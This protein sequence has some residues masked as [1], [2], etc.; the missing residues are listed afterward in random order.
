VRV[1]RDQVRRIVCEKY[2]DDF[3][4]DQE[5]WNLYLDRVGIKIEPSSYA[6]IC[7]EEGYIT[8]ECPHCLQKVLKNGFG[9]PRSSMSYL[10]VSE[11][12]AMKI[13]LLNEMPP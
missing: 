7:G 6:L 13:V 4:N 3:W 1:N 2:R 8:F 10:Y 5:A 9:L 11:E 12:L